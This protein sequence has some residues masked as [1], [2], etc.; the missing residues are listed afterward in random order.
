MGNLNYKTSKKGYVLIKGEIESLKYYDY[1]LEYGADETTTGRGVAPRLYVEGNKLMTWGVGGN[2][3]RVYSYCKNKTEASQLLYSIWE[4]NVRDN[5]DAPMFFTTKKDLF[6]TVA[7][8]SDKN[9]KVVKRYFRIKDSQRKIFLILKEEAK[10]RKL[11][12]DKRPSF[13]KDNMLSFIKEN[14]EEI[15][16]LLMDLDFLKTQ[17]KKV[18]WQVKANSLVQRVS[19]N[20]FRVLNWKQ[21]YNL[22]R[23]N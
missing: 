16:I 13:S 22:V 8:G 6:Q 17:E 11:G 10:Q 20:D 4:S 21:I 9:I 7:D 12:Y 23:E 14:K 19:N 2:N 3:H 1:L 5:W 18:E 15:S